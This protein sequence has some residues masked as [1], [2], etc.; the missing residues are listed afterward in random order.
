MTN[1]KIGDIVKFSDKYQESWKTTHPHRADEFKIWAS[2]RW[3]IFK[4]DSYDYGKVVYTNLDYFKSQY[5]IEKENK[6]YSHPMTPIF[7]PNYPFKKQ[8]TEN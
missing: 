1:L 6:L 7:H 8:K 5:D 4:Y 2:R 3:K